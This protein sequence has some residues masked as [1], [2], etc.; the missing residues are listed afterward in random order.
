MAKDFL[1]SNP[2]YGNNKRLFTNPSDLVQLM[3]YEDYKDEMANI[4]PLGK[5]YSLATHFI[6]IKTKGSKDKPPRVVEIPRPCLRYNSD[7]EDFDSSIDCPYCKLAEKDAV[8]RYFFN[9]IV[10]DYQEDEP[11][12]LNITKEEKKSGFKNTKSKSWTPVRVV[13]VPPSVV[14]TIKKIS[15][16]NK[17]LDK[18]SGEKKPFSVTDEKY[19]RDLEISFDPDA[20]GPK[21][22]TVQKGDA[23][24]LEGKEKEFLVFD[25]ETMIKAAIEAKEDDIKKDAKELKSLAV[26]SDGDDDSSYESDDSKSKKKKGKKKDATESESEMSE[27]ESESESESD[28]DDDKKSKKGKDKKSSKKKKDESESE[29]ESESDS[30]NDLDSDDDSDDDKKSKGKKKKGKKDESESESEESES[31]SDLSESDSDDDKKSKK[32]KDKKSKGK[33]K[34]DESES[35][36]ES[37]LSDSDD[38]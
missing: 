28:S 19:G 32:G 22:W 23:S 8:P 14:D 9:A 4:R 2:K 18:K 25:L 13:S 26:N 29:S 12:K 6:K 1:D 27:S 38:D 20:A 33:K 10:R 11:K 3:T 37:E 24:K 21:K 15:K 17:H 7:E 5:L 16:S 35:D 34:K 31:E 36:S 30:D